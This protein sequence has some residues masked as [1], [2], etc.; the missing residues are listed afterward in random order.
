MCQNL[1]ALFLYNIV[2]GE[3]GTLKS[4]LH[5]LSFIL[6]HISLLLSQDITPLAAPDHQGNH[7]QC[8]ENRDEDEDG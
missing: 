2:S 7:S 5:Q 1:C 3:V 6:F 4:V 8:E